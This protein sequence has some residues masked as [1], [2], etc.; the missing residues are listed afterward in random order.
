MILEPFARDLR[1]CAIC[2]DQCQFATVEV[3]AGGRQTL[4]TPRK[5]MLLEAVRHGE[6]DWTPALVDVVYAGLNSGVQHAVCV[7]RGDPD[8][9][10]DETAYLRAARAE[11]V[12]AGRAPAWA[13]ALRDA[14]ARSGNPYGLPDADLPVAG[15]LVFAVD[16]ATRAFHPGAATAWAQVLA[17]LHGP[18]GRLA[19]GSSGFELYDLGFVDEAR[20]A[21]TAWNAQLAALGAEAVISD[22]P[23]AV[24]MMAYIWP[25]WGLT[26]AAPAQPAA[27]WLAATLAARDITLPPNGPPLAFH[28]PACLAR[29]LGEIAAPRAAAERLGIPLVEM[30]RH[31]EEALPSGSY[32]GAA[33]GA[34]ARAIAADRIASARATVAHGILTASPFDYRNLSGFLPVFDLGE[35]AAARL[36]AAG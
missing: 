28:D 16:A 7:N 17:R 4:A 13:L 5:A 35:V 9:W 27:P 18:A 3:F 30:L 34:W 21:A 6:M 33:I 2:H 25:Q 8:G 11:I 26:P 10:P 23:E 24:Y 32:Y 29:Y 1:R 15:R 14:W 31:G 12:H 22:S 19:T 20:A 36:A